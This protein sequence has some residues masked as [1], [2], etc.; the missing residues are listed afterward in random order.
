MNKELIEYH[1]TVFSKIK[2]LLKSFFLRKKEKTKVSEK[3]YKNNFI[4]NL[5][6][7]EDEKRMKNLKKLYDNRELDEKNVTNEDV[8]KLIEM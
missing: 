2:R 6:L 3:E 7:N 4:E 8:D 5:T 1:E